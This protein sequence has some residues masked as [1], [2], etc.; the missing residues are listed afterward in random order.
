MIYSSGRSLLHPDQ[1]GLLPGLPSTIGFWKEKAILT[2]EPILDWG[3]REQI[4][5]EDFVLLPSDLNGQLELLDAWDDRNP[6]TFRELQRRLLRERPDESSLQ[7][8]D[9]SSPDE[10]RDFL[11]DQRYAW[12]AALALYPRP[13][14]ELTLSLAAAVRQN[15]DDRLSPTEFDDLLKLTSLPWLR[16]G[17]LSEKLRSELIDSLSPQQEQHARRGL[18]HLL[19]ASSPP[20]GSFADQEKK[21]QIVIQKA[22]LN[23]DDPQSQAGLELLMEEG[24]LDPV[25]RGAVRL[26]QQEE[27]SSEWS[28]KKQ[29]YKVVGAILWGLAGWWI[30]SQPPVNNGETI[31]LV[32]GTVD[33]IS[34][35]LNESR[36][37][38]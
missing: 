29:A 28:L 17:D 31:G 1:R 21:I 36:R 23:P 18:I 34:W 19:E 16:D 32:S 25:T 37:G 30:F 33:S 22:L 12:L 35:Y 13:A 27:K 24:Y 3:R 20:E 2:P 38:I 15:E 26:R 5:N 9:L 8:S 11:G 14:W 4:L 6:P 7:L 10:I